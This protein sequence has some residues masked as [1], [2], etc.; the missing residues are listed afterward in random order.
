MEFESSPIIYNNNYILVGVRARDGMGD[1]MICIQAD[2]LGVPT[3]TTISKQYL[4]STRMR[5]GGTYTTAKYTIPT[6]HT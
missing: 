2:A 4:V 5:S 1:A 3:F 6:P